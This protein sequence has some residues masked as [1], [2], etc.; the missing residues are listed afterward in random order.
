MQS[1]RVSGRRG[2]AEVLCVGSRVATRGTTDGL[3]TFF[4]GNVTAISSEASVQVQFDDG[5]NV[6][7]PRSSLKFGSALPAAPVPQPP[8]PAEP[9]PSRKRPAA[10]QGH[11]RET[12]EGL[13]RS[14]RAKAGLVPAAM[15]AAE[16]TTI[17]DDGGVSS[18]DDLDMDA[19]FAAE[20]ARAAAAVASRCP[21][22]TAA[23]ASGGG[24]A[25]RCDEGH[26]MRHGMGMSANCEDCGRGLAQ[27][28]AYFACA[29]CED[30]GDEFALCTSC[31]ERRLSFGMHDE[32][33][34]EE[35]EKEEEAQVEHDAEAAAF[36]PVLYDEDE[37][38]D[39]DEVAVMPEAEPAEAWSRAEEC[40]V[41]EPPE[42]DDGERQWVKCDR[43]QKWRKLPF[44][45][46]EV[47]E[48]VEEW[49]CADNPDR[50]RADCDVDEEEYDEEG[51]EEE[52]EEEDD[53]EREMEERARS[54]AAGAAHEEEE[55]RCDDEG[56]VRRS[57]AGGGEGGGL[58]ESDAEDE[59]GEDATEDAAVA[60]ALM[61]ARRSTRSQAQTAAAS[62]PAA[63]SEPAA[64]FQPAAADEAPSSW[65]LAVAAPATT[66]M[67]VSGPLRL[68][69]AEALDGDDE[70]VIDVE[71]EYGN[72]G[73]RRQLSP[74]ESPSRY[75]PPRVTGW[76]S[77]P[78]FVPP[79]HA[80]FNAF[81]QA[82]MREMGV[83]S[84][85]R[86]RPPSE[87]R[88][89]SWV[90]GPAKPRLQPYQERYAAPPATLLI[91][92]PAEDSVCQTNSLC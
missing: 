45:S 58:D 91:G 84:N 70:E 41:Q 32:G 29:R 81:A 35:E 71:E 62:E 72:G 92:N 89:A 76:A 48:N 87:L 46:P 74:A 28:S 44:G 12:L 59:I 3:A 38:E 27:W 51:A 53:D 20:E 73:T 63:S 68:A 40:A 78:D 24:A 67:T 77:H 26:R 50:S 57:R 64:A 6:T 21:T 66:S 33:E 85:D 8:V 9:A 52:E 36:E 19:A 15:P 34:E 42:D 56:A 17:D 25:V 4:F 23:P 7:V 65:Q 1:A 75:V 16:T 80:G 54:F 30:E 47:S 37:D 60:L 2:I 88:P 69:E 39:E 5:D 49:T 86:V 14:A 13:R 61:A 83:P 31:G 79:G 10:Q 18:D 11:R 22:S 82:R 43:C 55:V 90:H